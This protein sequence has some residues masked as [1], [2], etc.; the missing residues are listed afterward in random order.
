MCAG[1]KFLERNVF[2]YGDI[3]FILYKLKCKFL[4][5]EI[6]FCIVSLEGRASLE[7]RILLEDRVPGGHDFT[8]GQG[9]H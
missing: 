8:R 7:G 5:S 6:V 2:L 9:L 1:G 4:C 3:L